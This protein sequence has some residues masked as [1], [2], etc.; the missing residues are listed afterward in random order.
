LAVSQSK[1][2]SIYGSRARVDLSRIFSFLILYTV[3]RT[4]WTGDSPS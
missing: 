1:R 4:P 3:G 2:I